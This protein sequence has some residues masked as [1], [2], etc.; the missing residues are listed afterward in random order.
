MARNHTA[1]NFR[2]TSATQ[3]AQTDI[4]R[5]PDKPR[6]VHTH[7]FTYIRI[8]I[9]AYTHACIHVCIDKHIQSL[10]SHTGIQTSARTHPHGRT[11][12]HIVAST[13]TDTDSLI[14]RH[15]HTDIHMQT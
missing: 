5:R 4:H 6:L 14:H 10:L 7:I 12:T 13:H 3:K 15:M 1:E 11:S 9:D 2:P 8:Y